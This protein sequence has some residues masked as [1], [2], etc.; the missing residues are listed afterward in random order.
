MSQTLEQCISAVQADLA[1]IGLEKAQVNQAQRYRFRGIDD[2]YNAVSPI[3]AR[4]GLIML[5]RYSDLQVS[6]R[7]NDRGTVIFS[8][9]ILGTFEFRC[10]SQPGASLV[11]STYGEAMDSGDKAT[12]KAMSAALKYALFQSF[13]IPTEG[14]NDA[15]ATTH[16]VES[17]PKAAAKQEQPAEEATTPAQDASK[18][19]LLK[20]L[21][22]ACK[23]GGKDGYERAWKDLSVDQRKWLM[24]S[25]NHGK[26]KAMAEEADRA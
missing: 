20:A 12:N 4:H 7:Q 22:S 16:V 8:V 6:E 1:K 25:G 13:L 2:V 26:L 23:K 19:P 11:V 21:E 15:D 17:K 10:A 18:G 14:D 9:R 24:S 3:M 5:P